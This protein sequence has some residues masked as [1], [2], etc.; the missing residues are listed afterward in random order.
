MVKRKGMNTFLFKPKTTEDIYIMISIGGVY[1]VSAILNLYAVIT[2]KTEQELWSIAKFELLREEDV[3]ELVK[4][5]KINE[6][7]KQ[8]K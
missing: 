4:K 7:I 6:N 1:R 8:H 2:D 3:V 5:E